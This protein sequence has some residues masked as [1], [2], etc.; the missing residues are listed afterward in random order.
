MSAEPFAFVATPDEPTRCSFCTDVKTRGNMI[1]DTCRPDF[2][3]NAGRC[4]VFICESCH[5]TRHRYALEDLSYR[6]NPEL[7]PKEAHP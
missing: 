2:P 1:E 5:V 3:P 7:L 4:T 6:Q